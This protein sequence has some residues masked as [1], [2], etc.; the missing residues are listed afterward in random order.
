MCSP[1]TAWCPRDF[2]FE[3]NYPVQLERARVNLAFE[4]AAGT[5][6]DCTRLWS[7]I[8]EAGMRLSLV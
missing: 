8:P 1:D 3:I 5:T 4:H 6:L 2:D 7:I